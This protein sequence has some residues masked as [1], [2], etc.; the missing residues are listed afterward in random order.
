MKPDDMYAGLPRVM[1]MA[2]ETSELLR[3][4][5]QRGTHRPNKD[6]ERAKARL[7]IL[8]GMAK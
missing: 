7:N 1:H 5:R 4:A 8:A 6:L 2:G 3:L